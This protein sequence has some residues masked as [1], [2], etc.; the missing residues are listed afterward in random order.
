MLTSFQEVQLQQLVQETVEEMMAI[1]KPEQKI[2]Y[3]HV[4]EQAAVSDAKLLKNILINLISNAIKFSPQDEV[5]D[6]FSKIDK[7]AIHLQVSDHGM[8]ISAEDQQ[9]LFSS[10]FR[11]RN[12]TNIQGTGLGLHIVK[13]YVDLLGGTIGLQ[14]QLG[15]GTTVTLQLPSKTI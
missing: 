15:K 10:F 13:R 5:I 12:A 9:H 6:I 11:G 1:I 8:G 7:A 3:S 2:N 14:S 4:G